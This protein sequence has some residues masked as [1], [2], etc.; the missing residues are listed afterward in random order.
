MEGDY[1]GV[2]KELMNGS[3]ELGVINERVNC[4]G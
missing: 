1:W 4:W 3:N 2:I